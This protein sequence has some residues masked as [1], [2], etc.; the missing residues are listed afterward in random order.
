MTSQKEKIGKY[1][2]DKEL[3]RGA[4]GVVYK[5]IDGDTGKIWAIKR[6]N[7]KD[8]CTPK[9]KSLVDSEISI[10]KEITHPNILKLEEM[11]ETDTHYYLVLTYC[12]Q[13]DFE[14]Y[15]SKN[16][17]LN[18]EESEAVGFLKQIMNGF[19]ELRKR[20]ILHRDFKLANLFLN[21]GVLII[22][23]FGLAKKGVEMTSTQVGTPLTMAPELLFENNGKAYN[24]KADLWSIGCVYYQMLFGE[25]PFFALSIPELKSDIKKK[26]SQGIP[27]PRNISEE[28][29]DLIRRLLCIDPKERIEW[30]AFFNH[31][32]FS[33]TTESQS[34]NFSQIFKAL[35]NLASNTNEVDD[36]FE[37]NKKIL[38]QQQKQ[39]K[40]E[41]S[42]FIDMDQF[43]LLSKIIQPNIVKINPVTG[44]DVGQAQILV[45]AENVRKAYIH[46]KNK[47]GY[48][49]YTVQKIITLLNRP[50]LKPYFHSLIEL[51]LLIAKKALIFG[52]CILDHLVANSNFLGVEQISFGHFIKSNH[53]SKVVGEFQVEL[54]IIQTTFQKM[55]QIQQ[56][57]S[58]NVAFVNSINSQNIDLRV[59]DNNLYEIYTW[60][61]KCTLELNDVIHITQKQD[62]VAIL[63]L[64]KNSIYSQTNFPLVPNPFFPDFKF[65]W[66]D[67]YQRL[68]HMDYNQMVLFIQS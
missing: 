25:P 38:A 50:M 33:K 29:K 17:K 67:F 20:K 66:Q 8:I 9:L 48:M 43:L 40:Q 26:V 51:G 60:L 27:F 61:L 13:G 21:D 14:N 12:N 34:N 64:I 18:L 45:D 22:G 19:Q 36:E 58:S 52:G 55:I 24:S 7:K 10:M 23:D 4:F 46:E 2:L 6:L 54:S 65:S 41:N 49:D 53:V 42:D 63:V 3:G 31:S 37:K 68:T 1:V 16:S 56:S 32:L 39:P 59:L 5:A 62:L 57:F 11:L 44:S 35:T 47:I 30:D 15:M 28:S